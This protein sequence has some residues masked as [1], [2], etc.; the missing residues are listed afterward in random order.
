MRENVAMNRIYLEYYNIH[1]NR[2][3]KP[4]IGSALELVI[5]IF[6]FKTFVFSI[7]G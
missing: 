2:L 6:Y 3:L 7:S 4:I 1:Q 5:V